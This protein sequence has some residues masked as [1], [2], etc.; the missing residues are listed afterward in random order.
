MGQGTIHILDGMK[1]LGDDLSH[2]P[3][4]CKLKLITTMYLDFPF[5]ICKYGSLW[6]TETANEE[7]LSY[8]LVQFHR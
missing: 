1:R 6:I 3:K 4:A 8:D 2:S 5:N 7:R